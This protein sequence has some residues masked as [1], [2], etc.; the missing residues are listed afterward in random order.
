MLQDGN[1][2]GTEHEKVSYGTL[3]ILELKVDVY[4]LLSYRMI[5]LYDKRLQNN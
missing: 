4:S 1:L 5:I 2:D 3:Q